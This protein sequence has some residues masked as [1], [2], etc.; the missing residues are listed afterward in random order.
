[1]KSIAFKTE[2]KTKLEAKRVVRGF[3]S[4]IN[5]E[6]L[7]LP[8]WFVLADNVLTATHDL[9]GFEHAVSIDLEAYP[10][11]LPE[12]G[13]LVFAESNGMWLLACHVGIVGQVFRVMYGKTP[14][15]KNF[16]FYTDAVFPVSAT[17][18][19]EIMIGI[20]DF[21]PTN[22]ITVEDIL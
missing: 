3:N 15:G 17:E 13:D 12:H 8:C 10:K 7:K 11:F 18:V 2:V 21:N 16:Y 1:M 19:S 4:G 22:A 14:E 6:K 9:S 20:K 5:V